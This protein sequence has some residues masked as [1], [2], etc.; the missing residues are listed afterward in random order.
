MYR[1]TITNHMSPFKVFLIAATISLSAFNLYAQDL[2][3]TTLYMFNRQLYNPAAH[4]TDAAGTN[5]SVLYR[6]QYANIKGAPRYV[7]AWGDHRFAAKKM[8]VGLNINSFRYGIT[9]E[10][11]V[12]A[13]YAY[14]L[15]VTRKIKLSMGLRAGLAGVSVRTAELD[16]VWDE[17]DQAVSDL[18]FSQ[19]YGKIGAGFQVYSDLFYAG[20]SAPDLFS[21]KKAFFVNTDRS[22]LSRANYILYAGGTI[23]LSDSYRLLP[24]AITYISDNNTQLYGS[25]LF[26]VKQYFLA[27]ITAS[28]NAMFSINTG[29]YLSPRIRFGYSY[30][31]SRPGAIARLNTHELNIRYAVDNL[32]RQ[33]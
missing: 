3:R 26:E 13:N 23:N 28:T 4:G 7:S 20:I 12:M 18:H 11:E 6:H 27:G 9:R 2:P 31:F 19:T 15:P 33:K 25:L 10:N 21:G 5:A 8:A 17:D 16:N 32:F 14:L 1:T 22:V 24:S 29:A 30:E